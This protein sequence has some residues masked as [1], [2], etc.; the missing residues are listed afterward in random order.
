MATL[1]GRNIDWREGR[2]LRAWTLYEQGWTQHQIAEALGVTQGAISQWLKRG[3]SG[4]MSA[5]KTRKAP[6]ATPR[7]T[8]DQQSRLVELLDAG[9]QVAGFSG[10]SWN[11]MWVRE[12]I[13]RQFGIEYH[14]SHIS[15][16]LQR[17]DR[18]DSRRVPRLLQRHVH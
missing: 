4:G 6:G 9:P 8:L 3:R 7:L 13:M 18:S 2:R 15:R 10:G 11:R 12:L 1:S 14:V 5:L 17:L 16:I